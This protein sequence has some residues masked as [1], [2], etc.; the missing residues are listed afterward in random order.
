MNLLIDIWVA[1]FLIGFAN[2]FY[3][4]VHG[5]SIWDR[6]LSKLPDPGKESASPFDR[7]ARMHRYSFLYLFEIK[8]RTASVYLKVWLYLTS[9]TLSVYWISLVFAIYYKQIN[10]E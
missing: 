8:K 3:I 6:H 9:L 4:C 7:F 1:T 2:G 5:I 10:Y